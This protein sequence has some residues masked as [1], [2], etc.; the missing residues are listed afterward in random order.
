MSQES[1][2]G[3]V[4]PRVTAP[5]SGRDP[6]EAHRAATPL[7]LFFDLVFVVAVALASEGLHHGVAEGH[8][9]E[10]VLSFALVFFAIYWA[11]VNFTW[12]ASAYDNDDVVYRLAVF[13]TMTGALVF[14]AGVPAVF[15]DFDFRLAVLGY[16]VMRVALVL[17][18]L[19]VARSGA[20]RR[21]GALRFVVGLSA[22]Q[23]GW[24]VALLLPDSWW[25]PVWLTLAVGEL[26]VP[27]WSEYGSRTPWH[28]NHIRE[29]YGLFMMIVLGESV[30]AASRAIQAALSDGDA[31]RELAPVVV[32]GLLILFAL[33][34]VYFERPDD[35]LR[36]LRQS[37]TW[38]YLHLL[39]FASVAA[40]GA[41][42]AVAIEHATHHGE[43]GDVAAGASVAV[44]VAIFLL[45]TLALYARRPDAGLGRVV[46]PAAAVA[47][48][49]AVLTPWPVLAIGVVLLCL[50][51]LK[52]VARLRRGGPGQ[53]VVSGP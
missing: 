49:L 30:L 48:G 47:V 33:W 5:L 15:E 53:A 35:D 20:R 43:I 24:L 8:A 18:W 52:T 26:V 13:L 42:L 32:G 11:W 50:A 23:V 25:V 4:R 31:G 19:R 10:A 22:V 46:L 17:Q 51:A 29:R 7:E 6:S 28:P 39:I 36:T 12:F 21:A 40:V 1:L 34:W 37:F 3:H 16:A 27:I 9:A 14:A 44:P 41:G 45:S 38:S 2:V